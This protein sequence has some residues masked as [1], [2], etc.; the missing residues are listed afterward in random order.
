MSNVL[1]MLNGM[2]EKNGGTLIVPGSHLF[3]R[4][5]DKILDKD[6]ALLFPQ[7]DLQVV[8]LSQMVDYGMVLVLILLKI[9][10]LH[11]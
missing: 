11:F 4:H 3:G 9:T 1:I 5:P 8:L 2:S 10:D 6:I 7:K